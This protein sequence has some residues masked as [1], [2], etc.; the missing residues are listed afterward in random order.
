MKIR[1]ITTIMIEAGETPRTSVTAL[2]RDAASLSIRAGSLEEAVA[3]LQKCEQDAADACQAWTP[4]EPKAAPCAPSAKE[5]EEDAKLAQRFA[6][7][8]TFCD[9]KNGNFMYTELRYCVRQ[10]DR[11]VGCGD[12]FDLGYMRGYNAGRRHRAEK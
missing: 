12:A 2:S 5:Q 3:L 4:P 10:A 6:K 9:Q 1:T 8:A 11:V 7:A